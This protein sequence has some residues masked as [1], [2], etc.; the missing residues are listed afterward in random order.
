MKKSTYNEHGHEV[1]DPVPVSVPAHLT[2]PPT[3]QEQIRRL[4]RVEA[5]R[6]A[7]AQGH[8]TFEEAD[9]FEVGDDF[10]PRSPWELNYDQELEPHL[11]PLPSATEE[12]ALVPKPDAPN[13]A[14]PKEVKQ[15]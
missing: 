3:L 15:V 9:D 5:S 13:Q 1:P 8:E 4:I 11:D 7:A 10:D 2:R 6:V 14:P 12:V